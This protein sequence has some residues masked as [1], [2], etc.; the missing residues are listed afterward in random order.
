VKTSTNSVG[1]TRVWSAKSS[2]VSAWPTK[3][4]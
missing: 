4:A 2:E 1:L 3:T